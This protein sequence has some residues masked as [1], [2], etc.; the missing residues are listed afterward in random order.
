MTEGR[1]RFAPELRKEEE[2]KLIENATL[3]S[4]KKAPK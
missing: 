3:G 1:T 4:T 2:L